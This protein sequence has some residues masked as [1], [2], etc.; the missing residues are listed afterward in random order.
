MSDETKSAIGWSKRNEI[1]SDTYLDQLPATNEQ[2]MD[3]LEYLTGQVE[4]YRAELGPILEWIAPPTELGWASVIMDVGKQASGD[5]IGREDT[6]E[7]F[8]GEVD[9]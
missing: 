9:G 1:R 3:A 5:A 2:I 7:Q 4:A 8:Q 6:R